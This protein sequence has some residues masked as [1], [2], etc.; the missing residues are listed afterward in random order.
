MSARV[1]ADM[2]A[3]QSG[4]GS[5]SPMADKSFAIGWRA[6]INEQYL[7][8]PCQRPRNDLRTVPGT[9]TLARRSPLRQS[10]IRPNSLVSF[11]HPPYKHIKITVSTPDIGG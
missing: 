11:V 6:R 9:L 10:C 1:T 2:M 4:T 5:S 7:L 3:V 8:Q